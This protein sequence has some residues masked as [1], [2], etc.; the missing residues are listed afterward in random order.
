[1]NV[2]S[3]WIPVETYIKDEMEV[4]TEKEQCLLKSIS[5]QTYNKSK[6]ETTK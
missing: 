6:K 3:I 4:D 2:D 5:Q 1:M